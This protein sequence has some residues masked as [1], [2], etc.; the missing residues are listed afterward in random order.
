MVVSSAAVSVPASRSVRL[1]WATELCVFSYTN[2]WI[3]FL[4]QPSLAMVRMC[5]PASTTQYC[6]WPLVLPWCFMSSQREV[7]TPLAVLESWL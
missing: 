1:R 3:S 5:S 2:C 4:D 6:G 7:R